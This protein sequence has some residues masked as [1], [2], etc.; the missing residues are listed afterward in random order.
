[1]HSYKALLVHPFKPD[2]HVGGL[3][4]CRGGR[5]KSLC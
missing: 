2:W 3:S 1:M 4:W 5:L